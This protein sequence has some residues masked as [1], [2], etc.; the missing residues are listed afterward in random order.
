MLFIVN[1]YYLVALKD[2][3][4]GLSTAPTI[5]GWFRV[6]NNYTGMTVSYRN[7]VYG[8]YIKRLED[9]TIIHNHPDKDNLSTT[10]INSYLW[11]RIENFGSPGCPAGVL[12]SKNGE[13]SELFI[14]EWADHHIKTITPS[15]PTL[16]DK[17]KEEE[18]PISEENEDNEVEINEEPI[19]TTTTN[20]MID[21]IIIELVDSQKISLTNILYHFQMIGYVAIPSTFDNQI[22]ELRNTI[23]KGFYT[24]Y[25]TIKE[26]QSVILDTLNNELI[27]SIAH[28]LLGE[29]PLICRVW[30]L[31]MK[32][33]PGGMEQNLSEFKR[34]DTVLVC[35]N[36][37]DL[38]ENTY[39]QFNENEEYRSALHSPGTTFFVNNIN[40]SIIVG[41]NEE[42][43]TFMIEY[44][45]RSLAQNGDTTIYPKFEEF[46][47]EF[48][49]KYERL[50]LFTHINE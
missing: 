4:F 26:S 19:T 34:T 7:I 45:P 14:R 16:S 41:E 46:P 50:K 10:E 1:G 11:F 18:N 31:R 29:T 12:A 42:L 25:N 49:T 5:N 44:I 15:L 36:L 39:Y 48:Q 3:T 8:T 17:G 40:T 9:G 6:E 27:S 35:I 28:Y 23:P 47:Q 30:S 2:G 33:I 24:T 22:D 20:V 43:T 38:T 21:N 32:G 37:N 13:F